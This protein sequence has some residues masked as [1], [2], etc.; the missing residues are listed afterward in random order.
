[1]WVRGYGSLEMEGAGLD[2]FNEV[3]QGT[4]FGCEEENGQV[5]VGDEAF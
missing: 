4:Q 3:G 5:V 1:M 2:H